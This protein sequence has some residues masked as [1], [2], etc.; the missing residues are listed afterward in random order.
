MGKFTAYHGPK[1]CFTESILKNNFVIKKPKKK[2][3]H[4]LGHGVYFFDEY[5]LAHW[6]AET[7]TA[8]QNKKYSRDDKACVIEA[9]ILYGK[10]IDLDT[11]KGRNSFFSFWKQY[12]KE[13][14]KK[15]IV[16]DFSM[17]DEDDRIIQERK[18]CFALDCFK[19]EK[20]IDVLI[21]TFTRKDPVYEKSK[22]NLKVA[23]D[24]GLEYKEKQI[25]VSD[26]ARIMNRKD[27][28]YNDYQEVII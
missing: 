20:K 23:S 7:K 17:G 5:E 10:S 9:E 8:V 19:K 18:R 25:C 16:L 12:E 1:S 3:N 15:G 26:P 28:T 22:Y 6:W 13:I 21:Y 14:V 11:I 2:D 27:V 4:W 24:L